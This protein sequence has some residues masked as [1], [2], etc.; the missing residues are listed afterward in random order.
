MKRY[1]TV[2]LFMPIAFERGTFN[3]HQTTLAD[4][5]PFYKLRGIHRVQYLPA[6]PPC[7]ILTGPK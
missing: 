4:F 3:V 1:E 6:N 2:D 5:D 7:Y